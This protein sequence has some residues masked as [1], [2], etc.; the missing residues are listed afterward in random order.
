MSTRWHELSSLELWNTIFWLPWSS[1]LS[2]LLLV[3]SSNVETVMDAAW[4]DITCACIVLLSWCRTCWNLKTLVPMI[5]WTMKQ[6]L[7]RIAVVAYRQEE[8]NILLFLFPRPEAYVWWL[9][10]LSE[11]WKERTP[12]SKTLLAWKHLKLGHVPLI[13]SNFWTLC[14]G[15]MLSAM[16][17]VSLSS[18]DLRFVCIMHHCMILQED[19]MLWLYLLHHI[20]LSECASF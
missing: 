13:R 14:C 2:M 7:E 17:S 5:L 4:N 16:I 19:N 9:H 20:S 3:A 8:P 1:V 10:A 11:N 18:L 6:N 15:N 12:H